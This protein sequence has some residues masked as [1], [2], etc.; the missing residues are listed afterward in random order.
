MIIFIISIL[1]FLNCSLYS[2]TVSQNE[3]PEIKKGVRALLLADT[4][5]SDVDSLDSKSVKDDNTEEDK[6][7]DTKKK[8]SGI[9]NDEDLKKLKERAKKSRIKN[10]ED[11]KK[12]KARKQTKYRKKK[13]CCFSLLGEYYDLY[14]CLCRE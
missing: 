11:L 3:T 5:N 7:K 6:S 2:Q 9:R 10:D 1:L 13:N 12:L 8:K 14:K 4:Q